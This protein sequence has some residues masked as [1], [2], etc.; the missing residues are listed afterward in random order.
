MRVQI[1]GDVLRSTKP[2]ESAPQ[3][4][5]RKR[6]LPAWMTAATPAPQSPSAA[7]GNVSTAT[8]SQHHV[9]FPRRILTSNP[10]LKSGGKVP[11]N[12]GASL[13]AVVRGIR[14]VSNGDDQRL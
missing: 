7:K 13:T 14:T 2:V 1:V 3:T 9:M 12:H 11:V 8:A 10:E 5:Q 6:I 4:P